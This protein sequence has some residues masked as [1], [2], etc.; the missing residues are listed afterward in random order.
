MNFKEAFDNALNEEEGGEILRFNGIVFRINGRTE[1]KKPHLHFQDANRIGA[2]RLDVAEYFPHGNP[3][4]YTDKLTKKEVKMF[5]SLFTDEVYKRA[6][7]LWN[8]I[9]DG[10]KLDG[11]NK[12]NYLMLK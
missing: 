6:C 12:P 9:P 5:T 11:N 1:G 2:I 4:R 7:E 8:A 10:L 3:L